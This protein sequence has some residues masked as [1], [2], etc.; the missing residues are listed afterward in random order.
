[1]GFFVIPCLK[2]PW[3][4]PQAPMV[5]ASAV[6]SSNTSLLQE[7]FR[8]SNQLTVINSSRYLCQHCR[9]ITNSFMDWVVITG[10]VQSN[11][12]VMKMIKIPST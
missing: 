4:W 9:M 10:L 5:F 6:L 3:P 11:T 8:Y 2:H 7:Q 12:T 1:M